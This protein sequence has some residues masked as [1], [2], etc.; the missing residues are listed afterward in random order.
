MV[1]AIPATG[2]P[3]AVPI[4][5]ETMRLPGLPP[6]RGAVARASH[7]GEQSYQD[8]AKIMKTLMA[9]R[10]SG[11]VRSISEMTYV[12]PAVELIRRQNP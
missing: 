10:R 4:P 11:G 5:A 9:L 2:V 3:E 8:Y 6:A 7:S 1:A 12:H